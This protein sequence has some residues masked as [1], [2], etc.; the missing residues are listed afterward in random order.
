MVW[1]RNCLCCT[2]VFFHCLTSCRVNSKNITTDQSALLSLKSEITFDPD[3]ILTVNWSG[4]TSACDWIGVTCGRR[5]RRVTAL[6]VS[7]MGLVGRIPLQLGNLSFLVFLDVSWNHFH[8]SLPRELGALRHLRELRMEH[9]Q[10]TGMLRFTV[11]YN[12]VNFSYTRHLC[13]DNY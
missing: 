13:Y 7:G 1:N 4:E 2:F 11:M 8:G 5:H 6:D 3:K 10:L 9:N 12:L